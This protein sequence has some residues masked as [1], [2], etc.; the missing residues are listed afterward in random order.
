M[1]YISRSEMLDKMQTGAVCS[2]EYCSFDEKKK[3]GGEKLVMP[4]AVLLKS[5][6]EEKVYE[7]GSAASGSKKRRQ[8]VKKNANHSVFFTRNFRMYVNGQPT[9]VIRK[10]HLRLVER[11]NGMQVLP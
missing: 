5:D 11:F 7:K 3:K 6:S 10:V 4:E 1:I 9:A 2:L 8:L